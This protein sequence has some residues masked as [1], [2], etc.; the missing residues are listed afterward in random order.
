MIF[1]TILQAYTRRVSNLGFAKHKCL[2]F[3]ASLLMVSDE[4]LFP[5]IVQLSPIEH[6]TASKWSNN[7]ILFIGFQGFC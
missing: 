2:T 3:V 4:G 5:E 6:F 7:Y 1:V